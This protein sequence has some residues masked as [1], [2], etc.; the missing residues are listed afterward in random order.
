MG[1]SKFQIFLKIIA[2]TYWTA[3]SVK[4]SYLQTQILE[5]V[6]IFSVCGT[7]GEIPDFF[8]DDRSSSNRRSASADLYFPP[9]S[10]CTIA[11]AETVLV[12]SFN[13]FLDGLANLGKVECFQEDSAIQGTSDNKVIFLSPSSSLLQ[14]GTCTDPV[15]LMKTTSGSLYQ[16][17]KLYFG[18]HG[19]SATVTVKSEQNSPVGEDNEKILAFGPFKP[20]YPAVVFSSEKLRFATEESNPGYCL[21]QKEAEPLS[22]Q[23]SRRRDQINLHYKHLM[24]Y[25]DRTWTRW[26]CD[27][28]VYVVRTHLFLTQL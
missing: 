8:G 7:N 3:L 25:P 27:S 23:L 13:T 12:D 18:L 10:I 24:L 20:E 15:K 26:I 14:C 2:L 6:F 28:L 17:A 4:N 1:A 11:I 9:D 21:C 16:A 19:G 22:P 5:V